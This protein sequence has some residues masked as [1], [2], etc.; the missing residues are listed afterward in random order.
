LIADEVYRDEQTKKLI[1]IGTF[2]SVLA[3]SLPCVQPR[4]VVLFTLTNG[5]GS[6]D[7]QLSVEHERT[8]RPVVEMSGPITLD[9]PLQIVEVNVGLGGVVFPEEGKY[10]VVLRSDGEILSQRPLIVQKRVAT[11]EEGNT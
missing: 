6:Y 9:G 1:V 2:N 11:R 4:M 7:L 3:E 8:G 5:N 10:W